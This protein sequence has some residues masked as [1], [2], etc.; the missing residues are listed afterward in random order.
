MGRPRFTHLV[1]ILAMVVVGTGGSA[2]AHDGGRELRT[3]VVSCSTPLKLYD[4]TS[5]TGGLATVYSRGL[6]INL[7]SLSF[8]NRTSSYKVG[9][10]PVELAAGTHGGGSR[11]P[12]CLFAGCVENIMLPGWNNTISSVYLY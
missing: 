8:D 4:G 7:S 6:W 3:P 12:A 11:Y 1:L 5:L 9:A 2:Q 10:C